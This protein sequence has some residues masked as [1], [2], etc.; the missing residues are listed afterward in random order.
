ML[1]TDQNALILD[2]ISEMIGQL[3]GND[4]TPEVLK[5]GI[6]LISHFNV[7]LYLENYKKGIGNNLSINEYGVCDNYMQILEQC[8]ELNDTDRTFL[9]TLTPVKREN[10]PESGGWRGHKWRSYIGSKNPQYEYL[11][12]EDGIDE[13]FVYQIYEKE[14]KK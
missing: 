6:I 12:D 13:V 10:Q 3:N 1:K 8:P 9:I 5:E 14:N 2:P 7:N 11:Y 4:F